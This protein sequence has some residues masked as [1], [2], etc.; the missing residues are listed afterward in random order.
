MVNSVM[1]L[2][3]NYRRPGQLDRMLIQKVYHNNLTFKVL[4]TVIC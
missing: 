1:F 2:L 4:I 3:M